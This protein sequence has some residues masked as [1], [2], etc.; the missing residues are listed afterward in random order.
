MKIDG[1]TFFEDKFMFE[2]NCDF[3]KGL[4]EGGVFVQTLREMYGDKYVFS[5]TTRQEAEKRYAEELAAYKKYV[6][7]DFDDKEYFKSF[8]A[9]H[10]EFQFMLT[11][12]DALGKD[13]LTK[14]DYAFALEHSEEVFKK[15]LE[16]R[17]MKQTESEKG[18]LFS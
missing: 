11:L 16:T 9:F 12:M 13:F 3:L 10:N 14:E 1:L 15:C 17:A 5:K 7:S 8:R 4:H 6:Q 2:L 18:N